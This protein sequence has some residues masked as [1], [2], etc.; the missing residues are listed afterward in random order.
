[1]RQ[2]LFCCFLDLKGAYD[3]VPR[4]LLWQALQR[5][6]VHGRR[7]GALQSLYSNAE[8]AINM[9]GRRGVGVRF[10]RGVKQGCPLSPTLFGLLPDGLH[11]ALLAGASGAGP[12]L[13]CGRSV[14]DLGYADDFCLLATS[15]AHLQR[16]L[17]VAHGFLT[18]VGMELNV[19]KICVKA[20]GVAAA[21][22]AAWSCGGMRLQG[23][24]Q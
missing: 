22:G 15:P 24:E 2:P 7:L 11:W 5:L 12:Q 4:A 21:E 16:L 6:G 13:A 20:F 1:M 17:D 8:Y 9:G 18:S 23:V 19:N 14:P 3:R 10:T